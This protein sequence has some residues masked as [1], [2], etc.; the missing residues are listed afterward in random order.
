M[1]LKLARRSIYIF[2]L[3][4]I[5]ET[6]NNCEKTIS[7]DSITYLA[8]VKNDTTIPLIR[9]TG[10]VIFS[11]LLMLNKIESIIGK[12]IPKELRSIQL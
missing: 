3:I 6:K 9:A 10:K 2:F 7:V 1:I 8:R 5:F 4:S 12:L 11:V